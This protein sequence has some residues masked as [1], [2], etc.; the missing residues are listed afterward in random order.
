MHLVILEVVAEATTVHLS[1]QVL[2]GKV[3]EEPVGNILA[4]HKHNITMVMMV[5]QTLVEGAAEVLPELQMVAM[6][7]R[8]LLL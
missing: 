4:R 3:V 7:D 8:V 1:L 5:K 6:A 2:V